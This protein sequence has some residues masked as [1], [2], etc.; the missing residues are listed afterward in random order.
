MLGLLVTLAVM[1][2]L[3]LNKHN[4]APVLQRA[5]EVVRETQ[6]RDEKLADLE[7]SVS[8]IAPEQGAAERAR[9]PHNRA[10]LPAETDASS[11]AVTQEQQSTEAAQEVQQLSRET[12]ARGSLTLA[13]AY[14][15]RDAMER[16]NKARRELTDQ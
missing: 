16:L 7:I 14:R 11:A 12:T 3:L 6:N 8:S 2:P 15:L 10:T 4:Y 5:R 1:L 13:E 9:E